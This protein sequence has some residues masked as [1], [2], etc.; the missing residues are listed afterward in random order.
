MKKFLFIFLLTLPPS[1][2]AIVRLKDLITVKGV[3]ENPVVGYGLVIGLN[4][5][6]DGQSTL[7]DISLKNMFQRLGLDPKNPPS[8]KNIAAVIVTGKLKPFSRIGQRIDVTIS[9]IGNSKSLAGGTLLITPLKGG[10]GEIYAIAS[11]ALS[12][13]GL[14]NKNNF[15]TS[16]L[17]SNGGIIEKELHLN[18]DKKKSLRLNLKNP[19]FT[20]AARIQKV[21]N[22]NLGGIFAIS[23]DSTT[24]DLMIPAHYQRKVVELMA[25]IEN[26]KI[27]VDSIAK[28]VINEK[29]GSLVAGGDISLRPVAIAHGDLSIEIKNIDMTKDSGDHSLLHIQSSSK[30]SD[31]VKGL[32]AFGATPDDLITIFQ[33]LKR[34]G[35]LVADIETI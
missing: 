34:N 14:K 31:L 24:I 20:T 16:A 18:F 2:H 17:I 11:G 9:S 32:N 35:S 6:G 15:S 13:G 25:V 27:S 7:I 5:T 29:T 28:I 12:V 21:I 1:L 22:E 8:S 10:D 4:G 26:F 23:R 19:D 30:L 33:L 3:R